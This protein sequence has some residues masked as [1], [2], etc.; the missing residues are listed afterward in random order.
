MYI[1]ITLQLTDTIEDD[2][3][4]IDSADLALAGVRF[5]TSKLKVYED[6]QGIESFGFRGEALASISHVS[7]LE[8]TSKP[9]EQS[10]AF[11]IKFLDGKPL[12]KATP[13]AGRNGTIIRSSDLYYNMKTRKSTMSIGDEQNKI[14]EIIKCYSIHYHH[15]SFSLFKVDN[16]KNII[17]TDGIDKINTIKNIYGK[18]IG[19]EMNHFSER[20]D[21]INVTVQV[22]S[23]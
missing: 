23:L 2:G 20:D 5:A 4:G 3:Y 17:R 8:I 15:I 1:V 22:I 9:K 10:V 6:L 13:C 18:E 19:T 11:K 21:S 12:G 7:K 16:S 14:G